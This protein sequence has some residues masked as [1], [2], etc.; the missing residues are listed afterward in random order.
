M[1]GRRHLEQAVRL[2]ARLHLQEGHERLHLLLHRLQS[3]E[4]IELRLHRRERPSRPGAAAEEVADQVVH[5][6]QTG[7]RKLIPQATDSLTQVIEWL[8]VGSHAG[9]LGATEA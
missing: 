6:P 9:S 3:N 1:L 2:A 8:A 5:A 7:P 4:P